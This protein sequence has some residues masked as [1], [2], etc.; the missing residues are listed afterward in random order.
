ARAAAGP[1]AGHRVW[2]EV[3]Q[4]WKLPAGR[5]GFWVHLTTMAGP[6]VFGVLWGYPYLT[7]GLGYS[8]STASSL[9]LLMVAVGCVA[10]VSI[11]LVVTRR[12]VVRTP[13]AV[14]VAVAC[15]IGWIALIGWPGGRPPLVVLVVVVVLFA[16]GG[17]AS[18]VAFF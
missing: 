13:I 14:L 6:S 8:P 5:L 9:L 1:T 18:S 12:P 15:L 3:R 11:G 16:V 10:N 17:P 4:A 2:A 7:E